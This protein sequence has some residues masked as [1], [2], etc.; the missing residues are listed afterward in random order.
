MSLATTAVVVAFIRYLGSGGC[1][2]LACLH[3]HGGGGSVDDG[4]SAL[5]ALSY[6]CF[7]DNDKDNSS[8]IRNNSA[9]ALSAIPACLLKDNNGRSGRDNDGALASSG[10]PHLLMQLQWR[11]Q[12]HG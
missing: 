11:W 5:L 10:V 4:A 12:Q 8:N 7:C 9:L 6:A 2:F 1:P 3:N